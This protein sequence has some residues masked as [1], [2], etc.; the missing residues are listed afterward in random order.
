MQVQALRDEQTRTAQLHSQFLAAIN[1]KNED[2]EDWLMNLRSR[3][4]K[5]SSSATSGPRC[6]ITP[7]ASRHAIFGQDDYRPNTDGNHVSGAL[8]EV[9]HSTSSD[10]PHSGYASATAKLMEHFHGQSV[11]SANITSNT[12]LMMPDGTDT[13]RTAHSSS[14]ELPAAEGSSGTRVPTTS[15]SSSGLSSAE[16]V[17]VGSGQDSYGACTS[18]PEEPLTAN[19]HNSGAVYASHLQSS[20]LQVP[21]LPLSHIPPVPL[22]SAVAMRTSMPRTSL[23]G[24]VSSSLI[25]GKEPTPVRRTLGDQSRTSISPNASQVGYIEQASV[26][27]SSG[28]P[29]PRGVPQSATSGWPGST[30]PRRTQTTQAHA[31]PAS[32]QLPARTAMNVAAVTASSIGACSQAVCWQGRRRALP[33]WHALPRHAQQKALPDSSPQCRH[34]LHLHSCR[35]P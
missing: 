21:R 5:G 35:D 10:P 22:V 3:H 29:S 12:E 23:R 24:R 4:D 8:T 31:V 9:P 20:E 15:S 32:P 7:D 2:L 34:R 17:S 1:K 6:G 26:H 16:S 33:R 19:I 28:V 14:G 30:S 13:M 27:N 25:C 11:A 18:G